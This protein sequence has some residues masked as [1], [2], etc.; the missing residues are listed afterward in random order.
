MLLLTI[1]Y[2]ANKYFCFTL[3]DMILLQQLILT[4]IMYN[5]AKKYVYL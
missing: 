5:Y 2:D 3:H 1:G 4:K